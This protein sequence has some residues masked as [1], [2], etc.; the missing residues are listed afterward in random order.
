MAANPSLEQVPLLQSL[1]RPIIPVRDND[2]AG[3]VALSAWREAI[4]WLEKTL[5]LPKQVDGVGIKDP[6]ELAAKLPEGVG[7]KIFAD[8]CK[9]RKL[10]L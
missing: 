6:N 3:E 1:K 2:E 9:R 4:P 10:D 8:L 5:E 7:E